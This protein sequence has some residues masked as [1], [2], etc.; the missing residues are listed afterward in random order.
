MK[1]NTQLLPG[2]ALLAG[3]T[4]GEAEGN[5]PPH[6]GAAAAGGEV[7]QAHRV[8]AGEREAQAHRLHEQER[9]LHQPAGAGAREVTCTD[10]AHLWVPAISWLARRRG[11]AQSTRWSTKAREGNSGDSHRKRRRIQYG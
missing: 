7:S 4:G 2:F 3:Q 8:R 6:A 10:T 5:I 1:S 9:R 11:Q